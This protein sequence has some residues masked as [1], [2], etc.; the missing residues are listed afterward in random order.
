MFA[1]YRHLEK[2]KHNVQN[3]LELEK[4]MLRGRKIWIR[5]RSTRLCCSDTLRS[6]KLRRCQFQRY[7][8]IL[9]SRIC[10]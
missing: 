5:L 9:R 6:Q 4:S 8:W 7:I 10:R 1:D 3:S 2:Q